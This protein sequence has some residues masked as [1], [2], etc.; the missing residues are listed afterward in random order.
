MAGI[1][2]ERQHP[3]ERSLTQGRLRESPASRTLPERIGQGSRVESIGRP[4][5]LHRRAQRDVTASGRAAM[6]PDSSPPPTPTRR[7]HAPHDPH[8][9]VSWTPLALLALIAIIGASGPAH[10][11][12]AAPSG[13]GARFDA[14]GTTIWYEVRGEARRAGRS[15]WSTAGPGSITPT[16]CAP[17]RGTSSPPGGAWCSTTSAAP[18]ARRALKKG[19]SCTLADQIADLEALRAKLGAA[20]IDL[21]GHSWGGYLVM[22]YAVQHPE[23]VAHLIIADSAAPKWTDTDFIF[24]YIYPEDGRLA[25]AA[26]LR[27][28]AGRHH[29]GGHEHARVL[30]HAVRLGREARRLPVAREDLPVHA[31]GQRSAQ[32][33]PRQARH[34]A[35]CCRRSRCRRWCCAAASTSTSR[36]ARRGA[37]TR[38][39]P[40]SRWEVFEKSGHLPYFEEPEKFVRV[41]DDFLGTP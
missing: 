4:R 36:R 24:K 9:V 6:L 31:R 5:H 23:H 18:A 7:S 33:R 37:S 41:V 13:A 1:Q 30:G 12:P 11:T 22:A 25:G 38:R 2:G 21:L 10:A 15:S 32:R 40:G 16:C 3:W 27:R 29:G 39:S 17:T 19:Q 34:D 26:R 14:N 20:Q 8:A 28:G 35:R